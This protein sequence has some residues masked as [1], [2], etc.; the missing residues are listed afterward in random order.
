MPNVAGAASVCRYL[1]DE[2]PGLSRWPRVCIHGCWLCGMHRLNC[3]C[4]VPGM[5]HTVMAMAMRC[6]RDAMPPDK[7][8]TIGTLRTRCR[9]GTGTSDIDRSAHARGK[10]RSSLSWS[11]RRYPFKARAVAVTQPVRAH[12]V[13]FVAP[14]VAAV[15]KGKD[16]QGPVVT[17]TRQRKR[18]FDVADDHLRSA[19]RIARGGIARPQ[20]SGLVAAHRP[21]AARVVVLE[22]RVG[23]AID[24]VAVARWKFRPRMKP[25]A[26][27]SSTAP[28]RRSCSTAC[29]PQACQARHWPAGSSLCSESTR[30]RVRRGTSLS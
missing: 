9:S 1:F 11:N 29:F 25:R 7:A 26:G 19:D 15:D 10:P 23:L 24:A 27:C 16:A 4:V 21:D 18:H 17:R 6:T 13:A 8:S 12:A 28:V 30:C 20:S 5:Q 3:A 22:D 14:D 2:V